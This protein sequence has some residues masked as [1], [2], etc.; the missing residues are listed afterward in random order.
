MQRRWLDVAR[1]TGPPGSRGFFHIGRDGPEVVRGGDDR[2]ED[3]QHASQDQKRCELAAG[4]RTSGTAP[5]P[6]GEERHQQPGKIKQQFHGFADKRDRHNECTVL[7]VSVFQKYRIQVNV[8][9]VRVVEFE[10]E[11]SQMRDYGSEKN[12]CSG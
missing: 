10:E 7:S 3:D 6:A 12:G 1:L 2:K 4:R 9:P 8:T 5:Q 11:A